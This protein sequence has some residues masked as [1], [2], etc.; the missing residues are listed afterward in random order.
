MREAPL[1]AGIGTRLDT[2]ADVLERDARIVFAYLFG[3]AAR[4]QL[5]P[6]SDVDVAVYLDDP[7]QAANTRLDI[8][9]RVIGHLRTDR[10]DVVVLNMAPTALAGR[11]LLEREVLLDRRPAVRHRFESLTLREFHDFR[12]LEHAILEERFGRG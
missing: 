2:L 7:A 8:L 1:T 4:R 6:L 3:S 5:T 12:R 10:V 9:G 11:I